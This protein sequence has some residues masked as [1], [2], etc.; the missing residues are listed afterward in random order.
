MPEKLKIY[1]DIVSKV[2][3]VEKLT[4]LFFDQ[5]AIR[6][7]Y[8]LLSPNDNSKNQPY[9]GGHLTDLGFLPTGNIIDSPSTSG[10]TKDPKRQ[11]KYTTSLNYYWLSPEGQSYKAPNAKL[12]YYPQYPEVRFSGFLANCDI[13]MGGWMDPTKKGREQGRILFLGVKN[14]GEI[15]AYFAT[16]NSRIAKEIDNYKSIELT[17]VFRELLMP[18]NISS[19]ADVGEYSGIQSDLFNQP[20]FVD[21]Y[22]KVADGT[23]DYH[24][25]VAIDL[26][27]SSSKNLLINE[28][29]R[30]HL[31]RWIP[32]KR[33]NKNGVEMP[34]SAPNGGGY[35]MEAELGIIPNGIAEPD[36]LGWEVKQFGVK[37]FELINSKPLTVM[38]PEPNGGVYVDDGVEYFVRK[39]GYADTKGRS[40]RFNFNGRHSANVLC[41]KTG[42]TL[43]A[44]GYDADTNT[45]VKGSGGIVLLDGTGNIASSWSFTKLMEHWKCKHSKAVYIPSISHKEEEHL[46]EYF[47]GNVVRLFEGT[48]IIQLLK[49]VSAGHVYYD[50]GIKLENADTRPVTKRRSQFRI[51]S[52]ALDNLY[53]HQEIVDVL[54]KE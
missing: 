7:F 18:R 17:G 38:T 24:S 48:S 21:K 10:K 37:S 6:I 26:Q 5:G 9:M 29:K 45:I 22:P 20:D 1:D 52:A 2:L 8:K 41:V 43:V 49:A 53:D 16:P 12:I 50:P 28:L 51:K 3:S 47:Y 34:Y 36:Y 33:L 25:A 30:I 11:I 23:I 19:K 44:D 54:Q 42:L 31:K 32:G 27:V 46:K 40:N 14:K 39:Y 4:D 15:F 13:D 35:T